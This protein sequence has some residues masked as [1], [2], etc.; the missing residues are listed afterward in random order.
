[1]SD[2]TRESWN[3]ATRNHNAHKGDQAAFLRGGGD[4][5]F[6]E[7]LELL[8]PLDGRDLVH[9][10]CNAGQ[11]SLCLARRGARVLGVDFADEA[12]A[13]ARRLSA[14]AGIPAR[15]ELAE[16]VSWLEGTT[17]TF[18]L[19]FSSYGAAGWLPDLGAWA[20]GL[21]RVL[22]PG[23]AFVYVEF[24]PLVWSIG[25]DLRLSGDDYFAT[26]PFHEPVGDYVADSGA[27]L[28]AVA[29]ADAA[30][31]TPNRVPA[32]SYQHTLGAVLEALAGAGLVLERF[33]EHPYSNG[34]RTIPA[35]VLGPDRRFRWPEGTARLPLMFSLRV[36]R[37]G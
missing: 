2:R 26:E 17:E 14:A 25:P 35:L 9:L 6:P 27:G 36:R 24:H 23:G 5:L 20:R 11:D 16:V 37:P 8:G 34:C 4:L 22:R 13:F 10:Q 19:A 21:A 33:A 3:I 15:F 28:G 32:T 31:L 30:D 12:V 29:A 1:M 7:E 18:D